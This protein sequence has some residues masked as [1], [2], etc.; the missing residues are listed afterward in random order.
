MLLE[1]AR[2]QALQYEVR[3]SGQFIGRPEVDG[4][5]LVGKPFV[6]LIEKSINED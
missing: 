6:F 1:A 5:Q 3:W 4:I 2:C